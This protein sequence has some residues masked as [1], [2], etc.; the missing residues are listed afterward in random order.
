MS[1]ETKTI[2]LSEDELKGLITDLSR[3]AVAAYVK[4]SGMDRIDQ[5]YLVLPDGGNE[6]DQLKATKKEQFGKLA[7]ALIQKDY[8]TAKEVSNEIKAADPNAVGTDADGGYL[9]P[10]ETRAEIWRLIPTFGQARQYVDVGRFP[11]NRD[12]VNF[13]K[14]AT[15]M[16]VSYP[17]EA[18]SI[19]SSKPT[20]SIVQMEAKKAAALGVLTD[21]LDKFAIVDFANYMITLA[22]KSFGQDEDNKVFGKVNT[23]FTGLFYPSNSFGNTEEVDDV[24][25][26]DYDTLVNAV[27]NIDQNYLNGAAWYFNRTILAKVKQIKDTT[28]LPVFQP[29]NSGNPA[30]LLDFPV[31]I[32]EAAPTAANAVA[33]DPIILL[34]NLKN[35]YLKDKMNYRIDTST[36]G[37]VDSTSLFQTDMKAIRFIK[38]WSFHPGMPEAYSVIKLAVV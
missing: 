18:G 15:G 16:S 31:R 11:M 22:A 14:E 25:S 26:I 1:E 38:H 8:V 10:D 5:K 23:V 21:E 13:P 20:L 7:M 4:E 30:T 36:E 37:V 24:N 34:G 19:T 6:K 27:Y 29:A 9:V 28:G 17:G 3:E 35:S 12:K 2:Q 33:G 32:I